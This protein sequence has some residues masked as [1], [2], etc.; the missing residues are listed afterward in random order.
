MVPDNNASDDKAY[1]EA[2]DQKLLSDVAAKNEAA[3]ERLY[4]RYYDRVLQFV[5]RMLRDRRLA[6]EVVDDTMFAVWKSA[7]R[8]EGRSQVSTWIFGIAYRRALKTLDSNRR[9]TVFEGDDDRI[10]V[11]ASEDPLS[12]PE[13]AV[14]STEMR[15]HIEE[16]IKHLSD[17]HRAVMLLTVMGYSYDEIATI[18]ECPANTIKTR[19]FY[20]RKN[21]RNIL[22]SQV[23]LAMIN[24]RQENTWTHRNRIS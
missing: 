8:Y 21:L 9:H 13:A 17:D 22:S 7:E 6:E 12:N 5:S 10:A 11:T 20:A 16:G 23:I 19:M 24:K 14:T 2:E 3:F 1:V 15:R 4:K 18:V